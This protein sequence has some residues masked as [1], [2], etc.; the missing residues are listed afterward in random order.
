MLNAFSNSAGQMKL[1]T[2]I[3]IAAVG[4][5]IV[6]AVVGIFVQRSVIREQGISMTKQAMRNAVLEAESVR[7][8]IGDLNAGGAFDQE[9]LMEEVH[10]G[11][12][13]RETQLYKTIPVVAAW[14]AIGELAEEE[15][16][17]FRVPKFQARNPENEPTPSEAEILHQF[18]KGNVDEY[19]AID[20]EENKLVYARP[21]KLTADCLA[22]HGDPANSPTGDGRDILGFPMENWK[23][24]EVHGAFVLKSDLSELDSVVMAGVNKTMLW[25]APVVAAVAF[26]FWFLNRKIIVAPLTAIISALRA[27]SQET[28]NAAGQIASG[29]QSLAQGAS[30]QAASLEETS[31]SLEEM[32]SMT[33]RNAD[34]AKEATR[35]AGDS[36]T[37]T[38]AGDAAVDRMGKAISEIR[39]SAD[40]TAKIIKTID[41]IAFQT[42]LLALNAAVEAARAGEAGKG[43]AVVAEEVRTL[44]M[45]SAEAAKETSRM[46]EQGVEASRNGESIAVEVG[47]ALSAI[48]EAGSKVNGLIEEI[49][50]A[51]QEQA[52]GIE[53][54]SRAVQQMDQVTQQNAA[55]AEESAS[56]GEELSSQ[57]QRLME[58][59]EELNSLVSGATQGTATISAPAGGSGSSGGV[60]GSIG[61]DF[62]DDT[63]RMA[64]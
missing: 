32:S 37:A 25:I 24:G 41:E 52:Q 47:Q 42:N 54:V 10:S 15:G 40:E 62:D 17:D 19:F 64:A 3:L 55:N 27:G 8:T 53:Q 61:F 39:T 34:S 36:R 60:A 45:R 57:S 16:Y 51:S 13:L 9:K 26:G 56:A 59:V 44:A 49:S 1:G 7:N 35:L 28:R 6:T 23:A 58:A 12:P 30:E 48:N 20:E 5:V 21:I 22:C 63:G 11:V 50:A 43:F 46:I 2:K 33:R 29:S 38:E 4:A 31:S 14:Q 18:E